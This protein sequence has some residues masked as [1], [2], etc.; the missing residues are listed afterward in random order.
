MNAQA[1]PAT[2]TMIP[3]TLIA[4]SDKNPRKYFDEAD[5]NELIA[6]VRTNG[7][8]QP[9]LVRNTGESY[10]IV[11]GERRYQAA[12]QVFGEDGEIPAIVKEMTEDEAD[13]AALI[14]NTVRADMSITEEAVAASKMLEAADGNRD[15]AAARLGW[16]LSKLNRRIGLLNLIPVAMDALTKREI[17]VG[18]AELLAAIPQDKQEKALSTIIANKLT[19]QQ[20]KDLLLKVSTDFKDAIFCTAGCASCH[21]NSD[22]QVSLFVDSIGEGRCTDQECYASKTRDKIEALRAE[23]AE[24]VQTVKIIEIGDNGFS[25]LAADG[26][27]GVGEEQYE[28]C[29]SCQNFGAT[30]S[31]LP[32]EIGKVEKSI[33]FDTA[34]QQLKVAARIKAEKEAGTS[35][36]PA[37]EKKEKKTPAAGS[38]KNAGEPKVAGVSQRVKDYRRKVWN[39]GAKK[40]LAA[41]MDK[42]RIFLLD[43]LLTGHGNKVKDNKLA[44]IFKKVTGLEFNK[45]Y[46]GEGCI[47]TTSQVTDAAQLEKMY[48]AAAVC[49][50]E[51]IE[52]K[53][54]VGLLHYLDTDLGKHWQIDEE[55]AGMLTK[56]EL[57]GVCVSVGLDALIPDFKK[58]LGGK[59]DVLVKAVVE[60]APQVA[61][62]TPEILKY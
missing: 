6:S 60:A 15:E 19:V 49:A 51:D 53:R 23:L 8:L 12:L 55:F 50:V 62:T 46:N 14:E 16:P 32:G 22:Q 10:T 38:K 39:I 1:L 30:V 17:M 20:V 3:L 44:E 28:A 61:G 29:K 52:E 24:E 57:E 4:P 21:H 7:I 31:N 35:G 43:L 42:A 40:E 13:A 45:G 37:P 5:M 47:S 26:P 34:C 54:I 58:L 33:C 2:L 27:M 48:T 25:K 41:Q 36:Q 56:S 59:K 11:A 9:I 18:H